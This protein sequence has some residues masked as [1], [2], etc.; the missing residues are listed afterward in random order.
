MANQTF[1]IW[2]KIAGARRHTYTNET[3][4]EEDDFW[5]KVKR[6]IK[7][8]WSV[9]THLLNKLILKLQAKLFAL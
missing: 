9:H 4:E 5:K 8:L 2:I 6:K 1:E 7:K 3:M